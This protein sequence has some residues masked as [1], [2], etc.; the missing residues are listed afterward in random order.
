MNG[1][2]IYPDEYTKV[3]DMEPGDYAKDGDLWW[4]R[5]P[6]GSW[7]RTIL[8]DK[9]IT[10]HEDGSI[11]VAPYIFLSGATGM[12]WKGF[13]RHGIWIEAPHPNKS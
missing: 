12:D 2:R 8:T 10:E 3:E 1:R 9:Q 5:G 11:T 6:N 4:F 7:G 13:L